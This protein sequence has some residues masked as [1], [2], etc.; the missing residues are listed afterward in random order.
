VRRGVGVEGMEE[1]GVEVDIGRM[2]WW[3]GVKA[4]ITRRRSLGMVFGGIDDK[5]N[6]LAT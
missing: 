3:R 4:F 5:S 2:K 6:W 1:E